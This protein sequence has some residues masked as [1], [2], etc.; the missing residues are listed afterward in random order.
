MLKHY[1][2]TLS[3]DQPL[4]IGSRP[5]FENHWS[6]LRY[7]PG[8]V[9]RGALA[10]RIMQIKGLSSNEKHEWMTRYF[11]DQ[12]RFSDCHGEG[13][14]LVT[15]DLY[16]YKNYCGYRKSTL[17]DYLFSRDL[18]KLPVCKACDMAPMIR[19][20]G[21]W[22]N[23]KIVTEITG[24]TAIDSSTSA[25]LAVALFTR[26]NVPPR[27]RGLKLSIANTTKCFFFLE[28]THSFKKLIHT[29]SSMQ[30]PIR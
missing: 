30:S 16:E 21:G 6:T 13:A 29:G 14:K 25:F 2:V 11:G 5:Q 10:E 7:V 1:E 12:A 8:S 17:S 4:S 28:I 19:V 27:L 20:E 3:M 23:S 15:L 24:H 18:V 9:W 26:C 22:D